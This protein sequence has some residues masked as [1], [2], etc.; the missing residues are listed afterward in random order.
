M[1]MKQNYASLFLLQGI[2]ERDSHIK[3]LSEQVEEYTKEMEK[4]TLII[5]DL[6]KQLGKDKGNLVFHISYNIRR[7]KVKYIIMI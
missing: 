3:L 4:N 1:L 7:M 5:E 6:K 2:Q